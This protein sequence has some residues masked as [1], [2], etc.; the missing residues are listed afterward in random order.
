MH[1]IP[2]SNT[3]L[4]LTIGYCYGAFMVKKQGRPVGS[5]VRQNIVEI[6]YFY[7]R[8]YG[9]DLYKIYR[10]L[11]PPVTMRLIYYHLKKGLDTGEFVVDKIDKKS[12]KYS[13]GGTSENILYALGK[14]ANPM[15]EPH[16]KSYWEKNKKKE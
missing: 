5:K 11:Y 13:W 8:L 10:E 4:K 7:K 1:D 12:G 2:M 16:V 6:L 9:Y 3:F 15:I 14:N